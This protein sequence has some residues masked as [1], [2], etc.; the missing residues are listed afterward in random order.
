MIYKQ[1]A[2][3][4]SWIARHQSANW[5]NKVSFTQA[6]TDMISCLICWSHATAKLDMGDLTDD[7]RNMQQKMGTDHGDTLSRLETL[8][9][10]AVPEDEYRDHFADVCTF[11]RMRYLGEHKGLNLQDFS[12]IMG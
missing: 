5:T 9:K 7:Y 12:G 6:K 8:F 1:H 10:A 4:W 11:T 3:L 2:P